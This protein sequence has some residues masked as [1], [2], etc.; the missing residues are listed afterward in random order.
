MSV[1]L[2]RAEVMALSN[3]AEIPGVAL[4]GRVTEKTDTPLVKTKELWMGETGDMESR[5]GRPISSNSSTQIGTVI[6]DCGS[7]NTGVADVVRNSGMSK[8]SN[9]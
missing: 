7:S 5:S 6:V 4:F 1:I 3:V 2:P 8:I 9:R